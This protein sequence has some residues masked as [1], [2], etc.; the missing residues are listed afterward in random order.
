M[1]WLTQLAIRARMLFGRSRAATRLDDELAFHLDRQIAE[2]ISAGMSP[3]E[4]RCAALRV[5]GNPAL[6]R[7]QARTAWNWS[8]ME[9]LLRDL[10]YGVRTLWR[11][12][13]FAFIAIVIM[14]LGIGAN[15]AL[16][17]VVRNVLLKPLPFVDPNRLLML[18]ES[19]GKGDQLQFGYNQVAGGVYAEWKKQN[20]SFSSL[21]LVRESRVGLSASNGQLPEKLSSGQFSWDMLPTL[22][23]QPTI[24]RNFT[25]SDDSLSANGT[26]LLSWGLWKRRFGADPAI[27]NRTIQIDSTPYTVIGVMP[28]WFNFPD[29]ST[30]L[31]TP[32]HHEWP[33]N[34]INVLDNH[35]F[36]AVGRLKP[37][38]TAAQA[39]ADLANISGQ[40]RAAHLDDAFVMS[41]AS[42][43]PLLE[44]LVGDLRTPLYVLL[45]ATF[46]VL[47]IACLN[48][49]NLLVAR[50]AA[51][52]KDLAIRTALGGGWLRL[53][54]ERLIESLL[55]SAA[56][57]ALGVALA[58]SAL[59]W[60]V[61]TR[62]DLSRV[63]TVHLDGMV[64]A[65]TVGIIVL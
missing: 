30:Q 9:S 5:F 52:R 26:V 59:A 14:A 23:V 1:R 39:T 17:T 44:H 48:V 8:T 64:A 43:R 37:G 21:A 13:G 31:W 58:A 34:R 36:H 20:R 11:T 46:C 40:I 56:G 61:R 15:V 55:L 32:V 51:R 54:R 12:P 49:A 33:E 18:Y 16:F 2:N 63:E 62:T 25:A 19:A 4:A 6:T 22:G 24:G 38:V 29:A 45:A 65:F 47:L 10:R 35:L 50:A 41:S 27:L 57:G 53:V 42:S 28:A 60:F 3:E 7:D